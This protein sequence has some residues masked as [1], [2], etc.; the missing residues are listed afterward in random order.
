[1][2]KGKVKEYDLD[3]GDG[4]IVDSETGDRLI[5][6]AN[7]VKLKQK[8]FLREGLVVEYETEDHRHGNWAVNVRII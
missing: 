2:P 4:I 7:Y 6:Y 3:H 1:M 8:K 5:V